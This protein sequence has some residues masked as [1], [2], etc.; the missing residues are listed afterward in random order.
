LHAWYHICGCVAANMVRCI[1][2][3]VAVSE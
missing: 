1:V 2:G 3:E